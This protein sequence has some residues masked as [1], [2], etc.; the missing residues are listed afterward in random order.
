MAGV[1]ALW[2][3]AGFS[4]PHPASWLGTPFL[5]FAF[6]RNDKFVA[7]RGAVRASGYLLVEVELSA[8]VGVIAG[9]ANGDEGL[10]GEKAGDGPSFLVGELAA[11]AVGREDRLALG[12][13]HGAQVVEGAGHEAAAIGGEA[14]V[15]LHGPTQLL[16][17]RHA[18]IGDGLVALEEAAALVG[19]HIVQLGQTVA[20][21]LLRF[22]REIAEAGFAFKRLLLL[23]GGEVAVAIEPLGQMA[24]LSLSA[25]RPHTGEGA[26]RGLLAGRRALLRDRR[27]AR[28][29]RHEDEGRKGAANWAYRTHKEVNW[30]QELDSATR[31]LCPCSFQR[32]IFRRHSRGTIR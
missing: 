16:A 14:A 11:K 32:E 17:L 31:L 2:A 25:V 19:R 28:E 13:G 1:V 21:A 24:A 27:D 15:L 26:G 18:Q 12:F 3:N 20:Q 4:S 22:G 29:R 5:G 10:D 23:A 7:G 30:E 6:A 8:G 9:V